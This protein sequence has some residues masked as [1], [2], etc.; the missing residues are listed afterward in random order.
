MRIPHLEY[1]KSVSHR[2]R[3]GMSHRKREEHCWTLETAIGIFVSMPPASFIVLSQCFLV[4]KT[5]S[6]WNIFNE[7]IR[8]PLCSSHTN[9][10]VALPEE[11]NRS[12]HNCPAAKVRHTV[13][14]GKIM[15][16][17]MTMKIW[18]LW[19]CFVSWWFECVSGDDKVM[20]ICLTCS[21]PLVVGFPAK[22]TRER[23][24]RELLPSLRTI[25]VWSES[26]FCVIVYYLPLRS[27][28][29][30]EML[31]QLRKGTQSCIKIVFS[32]ALFVKAFVWQKQDMTTREEKM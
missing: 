1:R 20:M 12:D 5:L 26:L 7:W 29:W 6:E 22:S 9:A 10:A 21:F 11:W 27:F 16:C 18:S 19:L 8:R 31:I 25:C 13:G 15:M 4:M 17:V 30:I 28:S 14:F 2:R 24:I 23:A 3:H 32:S